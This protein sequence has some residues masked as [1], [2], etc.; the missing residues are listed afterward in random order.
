MKFMDNEIRAR[1]RSCSVRLKQASSE[2]QI[3]FTSIRGSK[4]PFRK[5][6]FDTWENSLTV[7]QGTLLLV[8]CG[9]DK[10]SKFVWLVPVRD[11]TVL[12]IM[13]ALKYRVSSTARALNW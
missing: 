13:K 11:A 4:R 9:V 3:K 6:F 2:F 12:A 8:W 5:L 7:R 1:I 10:S